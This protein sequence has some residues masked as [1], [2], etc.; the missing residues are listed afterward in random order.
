M[1][2]LL[3]TM[4]YKLTS[5]SISISLSSSLIVYQMTY[6]TNT[7]NGVQPRSPCGF[8]HVGV[9]NTL[10]HTKRNF[11]AK[12]KDETLKQQFFKSEN[13]FNYTTTK[14]SVKCSYDWS[15]KSQL[16]P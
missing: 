9:G 7:Q 10:L 14:C 8:T 15:N 2:K 13:N 4:E 16:Q 3:L 12:Q 6:T 11:D 1:I 5:L